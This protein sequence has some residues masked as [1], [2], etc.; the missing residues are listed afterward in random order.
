MSA[1][2]SHSMHGVLLGA[3]FFAQFQA[4]ARKRMSEVNLIA[5]A[6]LAL[7]RAKEFTAKH[8]IERAYESVEA[9]FDAERPDFVDIATRPDTHLALT[10][11]ATSRGINVISQKPMAP[12]VSECVA[13]REA[14]EQANLRLFIH[15]N[16]RWQPWY[17]EAK[18]LIDAGALGVTRKNA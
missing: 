15:E 16:W 9:M 7:G 11:L 13:I 8:G 4:E 14:C 17:R 3:G 2:T 18:R 10:R 12:T 1:N 6:A 5:V